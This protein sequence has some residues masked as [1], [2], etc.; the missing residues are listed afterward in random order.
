MIENATEKTTKKEVIKNN[1]VETKVRLSMEVPGATMLSS[2]DCEKM[3]KKDSYNHK[4]KVRNTLF[5]YQI[6]IF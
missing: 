4:E 1:M 2:Q 5:L 6:W 3:S